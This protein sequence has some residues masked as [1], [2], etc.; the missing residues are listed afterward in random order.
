MGKGRDREEIE[1]GKKNNGENS[2][3]YI[4]ASQLPEPQSTGMPHACAKIL[5]PKFFLA[6]NYF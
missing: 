1:N 6:K 2:G 3:H 4:I 5:D